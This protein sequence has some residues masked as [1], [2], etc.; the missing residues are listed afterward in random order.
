MNRF[1]TA[2][3]KQLGWILS[4]AAALTAG[5]GIVE[6]L[7]LSMSTPEADFIRHL[8]RGAPHR[9]AVGA[10]VFVLLGMSLWI[11]TRR[12][13]ID[14]QGRSDETRYRNIIETMEEGYFEIDLKGQLTFINDAF[15][16]MAGRTPAE[17]R[18]LR[19]RDYTT[20]D[21]ATRMQHTLHKVYLT[22]ESQRIG[23]YDVLRPDG[24]RMVLELSV[25]QVKTRT[26]RIVGFRGIARDVS[27][28]LKVAR[29]KQRLE[30]QLHQARK[31]E[32][33]GTLA[34]GIAHD[35]NNIMMG[36][37]GNTSL[38][39]SKLDADH[40]HFDKLANIEKYV[41]NGSELTQQLLGFAR[42]GKYN[43]KPTS[44]R[45]LVEESAQMFGRTKKEIRIHKSHLRPTRAVAV[46][47]GQIEQVLLNLF[48]NA[49]QAMPGGGDLYLLTEDV[50]LSAGD[51]TPYKIIPGAYVKLAIMDTGVGMD[52]ATRKRIFEP[53]FTTKEMGR[54]SGLGLASAY[55]IIK[56]HGGYI[57]V[58]S[59][60]GRGTTFNLYLPA[61]DHRQAED[62]GNSRR[63]YTGSETILL[64]DDEDITM[65]V[66]EELLEELGYKVLTARNG[67]DALSIYR[68]RQARIDMV[69]LD[70]VMPGM[71]G[72]PTYDALKKINPA[73]KVL[74]ASGYSI[75]GEASR[76]MK[77]GCNAFIQKPF[78]IRQLSEKIRSVLDTVECQS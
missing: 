49:W 27:E 55:G 17:M 12:K 2:D 28:K 14:A 74:L 23:S 4:I 69:I 60:E 3:W 36:I 43:V 6:A 51:Q 67:E 42:G 70:M 47:R 24:Q 22:G 38:M 7:M 71:G 50:E 58:Y 46:D 18:G 32:A 35:F 53:F 66:G 39:I 5:L 75:S 41:G 73:V 40:P 10:V 29:E 78:N 13:R 65:D 52:E 61:C 20:A 37:L 59:E 54:G 15:A 1:R 76:I 8:L 25:S 11:G 34:S 77:R 9:L 44:L 56:N 21:T 45:E 19:T 72:G 68:R 26:G 64:V 33:I 31:M 63:I 48:V 16:R 57:N 62:D 30:S